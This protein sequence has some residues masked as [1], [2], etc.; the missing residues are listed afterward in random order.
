MGLTRLIWKHNIDCGCAGKPEEIALGTTTKTLRANVHSLVFDTI[1]RMRSIKDNAQVQVACGG[2]ARLSMFKAIDVYETS[3]SLG[4]AIPLNQVR[5]ALSVVLCGEI[6]VKCLLP[7]A[8]SVDGTPC[9]HVLVASRRFLPQTPHA[10]SVRCFAFSD[11]KTK[12]WSDRKKRFETCSSVNLTVRRG[13]RHLGSS[14]NVLMRQ[15][16]SLRSSLNA[17]SLRLV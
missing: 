14:L 10:T 8:L 11:R 4:Q 7:R 12:T 9:A 3:F 6:I 2:V 16:C 17:L 15:R 13:K 1:R 5:S